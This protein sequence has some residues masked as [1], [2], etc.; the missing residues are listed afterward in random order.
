MNLCEILSWK[1][2]FVPGEVLWR[3]AKFSF[4]EK[5]TDL[6]ENWA[7]GKIFQY[8]YQFFDIRCLETL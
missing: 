3:L 5:A 2:G 8:R 1:D 6:E 4:E 7:L